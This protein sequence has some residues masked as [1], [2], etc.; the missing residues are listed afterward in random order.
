MKRISLK[1]HYDSSQGNYYS[2]YQP[3]EGRKS[4]LSVNYMVECLQQ[5]VSL[6]QLEIDLAQR[7]WKRATGC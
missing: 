4:K 1:I 2:P 6:K 3:P 7:V 5:A